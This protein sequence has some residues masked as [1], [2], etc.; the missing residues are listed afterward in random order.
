MLK[1]S[2]IIT[3]SVVASI[4]LGLTF[5]AYAR[6]HETASHELTDPAAGGGLF[7]VKCYLPKDII[8]DEK[9]KEVAT[10]ESVAGLPEF[11]DYQNG[12]IKE[13]VKPVHRCMK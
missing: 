8:K 6:D 11:C 12:R 2:L 3:L 1:K 10:C 4:L 9:A 7:T 5:N 13:G